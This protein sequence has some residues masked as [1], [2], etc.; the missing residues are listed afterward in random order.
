MN[1]PL[2]D[3]ETVGISA[4]SANNGIETGK[5][6]GKFVIKAMARNGRSW[7]C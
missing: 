5:K 3:A 2:V 6:I 4:N 1:F 7:S